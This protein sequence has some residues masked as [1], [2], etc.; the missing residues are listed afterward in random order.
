MA[1]L[2]DFQRWQRVQQKADELKQPIE[3]HLRNVWKDYVKLYKTSYSDRFP[4]DINDISIY[5]GDISISGHSYCRGCTD[6][7][8]CRMPIAFAFGDEVSRAELIRQKELAN[9]EAEEKAIRLK[10]A[11]ELA[12]YERLQAK[13]GL[14]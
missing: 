7:D 11:R 14:K 8:S 9:Q 13:F 12:E 1:T 3:D 10:E 5:N 2:K 6:Y 4:D